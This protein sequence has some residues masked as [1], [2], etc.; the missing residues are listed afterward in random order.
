MKK[1]LFILSL[2]MI[3]TNCS[4]EETADETSTQ[5][6]TT[7]TTQ[8]DTTTT[9]QQDTTTTTQQDTTTTTQQDT[10]TTTI[11][12]NVNIDPAE[13]CKENPDNEQCKGYDSENNEGYGN[14]Q[15]SGGMSTN[16]SPPLLKIY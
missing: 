10:T 13:F 11:L 14:M 1:I 2:L 4:G 6:D 7:T 12:V 9:T 8:Q 5:Q 16:D 15:G 3:F